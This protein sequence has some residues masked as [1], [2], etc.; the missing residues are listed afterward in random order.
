MV[1]DLPTMDSLVKRYGVLD[2]WGKTPGKLKILLVVSI[3][4]VDRG[5]EANL[6]NIKEG[7]MGG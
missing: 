4:D 3:L 2:G 5:V 7:D 1:A 6:V